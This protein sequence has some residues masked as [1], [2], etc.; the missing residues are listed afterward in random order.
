MHHHRQMNHIFTMPESKTLWY[1]SLVA[2][3]FAALFG[4]DFEAY[5]DD[6]LMRLAS[7]HRVL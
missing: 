2:L 1:H 4:I 7:V 6:I 3:L 5:L